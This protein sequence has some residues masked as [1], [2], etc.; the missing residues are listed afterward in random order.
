MFLEADAD[1]AD[2]GEQVDEGERRAV[3]GD[4]LC[5]RQ[6]A[7]P[8]CVG[9]VRWRIR[10]ADFPTSQRA[11]ADAEVPCQ[12]T[13]VVASAQACQKMAGVFHRHALWVR[14]QTV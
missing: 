7:L 9:K 6:Q 12:F 5:Q 1:P 14:C 13:L 11:H 8:D 10:F 4:V 3:A 2:A